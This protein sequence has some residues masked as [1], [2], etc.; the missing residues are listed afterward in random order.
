MVILL[1]CE[2]DSSWQIEVECFFNFSSLLYL[3]G[4]IFQQVSMFC[5]R[6][7]IGW[8]VQILTF[9]ECTIII[10]DQCEFNNFLFLSMLNL[11]FELKI[12]LSQKNNLSFFFPHSSFGPPSFGPN[13]VCQALLSHPSLNAHPCGWAC[14]EHLAWNSHQIANPYPHDM[15]VHMSTDDAT[16]S[17]KPPASLQ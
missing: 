1:N 12:P 15:L 8:L 2:R 14:I 5:S 4:I 3:L 16:S 17:K 9:S 7:K 11:K 13:R 10:Y 6:D